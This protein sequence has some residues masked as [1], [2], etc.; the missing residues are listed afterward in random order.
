MTI[1]VNEAFL[2]IESISNE[3]ARLLRQL[4][5]ECE[6]ITYNRDDA[7][8]A[9]LQNEIYNMAQLLEKVTYRVS[10]LNRPVREEGILRHNSDGR[11]ELP[12][13]DYFTSGSTIE[14]LTDKWGDPLW[15]VTAIEHNGKDYYAVELGRDYSID[16]KMARS[17][18]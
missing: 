9:F 10:Y 17:R 6:E 4:G 3:A 2:K 14:I 5:E 15:V 12:S 11:Y 1:H 7:E 16:G 18:R 13:G 8:Q